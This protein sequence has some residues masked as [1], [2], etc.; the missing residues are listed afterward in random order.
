M[1]IKRIKH[2]DTKKAEREPD[3]ADLEKIS[4]ADLIAELNRRG[5]HFT[6]KDELRIETPKGPIIAEVLG[7]PDE[8]PGIF[9]GVPDGGYR[10]LGALVEYPYEDE[11]PEEDHAFAYKVWDRMDFDDPNTTGIFPPKAY[12][13]D[14]A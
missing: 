14:E 7:A 8:Y 12:S 4:D 3:M 13:S 11:E 10:Q 5:Y 9:V 2:R 6:G 1:K